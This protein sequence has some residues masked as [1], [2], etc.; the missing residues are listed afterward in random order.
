M[1]GPSINLASG[2]VF[3]F[4][5]PDQC[6]FRIE[7]IAQG[8]S[9][10]CRFAG[11][12]R[13]FYSVA[14]HSVL[15]SL[16]APDEHALQALLHDAAEAFLGDVTRPLKSMLP[17]YRLIEQATEQAIFRRYSLPE[18][19]PP[20]VKE[21]D[22]AVYAAERASLS[23]PQHRALP[24]CEE[25]VVAAPVEIQCLLPQQARALFMARYCEITGER[26]AA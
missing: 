5:R 10:V 8:L 24:A 15:V 14:E 23:H 12:S 3:Y 11:Q 20:V 9:N 13:R 16:V 7:D 19:I 18:V 6:A 4:E 1:I 26:L 22:W 25:H 17:G 2:D 21:A